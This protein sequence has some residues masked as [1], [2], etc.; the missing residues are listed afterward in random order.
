M[1]SD[2]QILEAD[3]DPTEG[4]PSSQLF[5][6]VEPDELVQAMPLLRLA[7][8]PI[9]R[10]AAQYGLAVKSSYMEKGL[11][12][13]IEATGKNYLITINFAESENRQRFTVAHEIAHFLLHKQ[14]LQKGSIVD[15]VLYRSNLSS[16]KEAEANRLAASLL[17]PWKTVNYWSSVKLGS[18]PST[19]NMQKIATKFAVSPLVVAFRFNLK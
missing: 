9:G 15:S 10:I 8:V 18:P 11:S 6:K 14:D 3:V 4:D 1:A 12:G 2:N 7:P 13:K 19:E 5:Q 17:L 16:M